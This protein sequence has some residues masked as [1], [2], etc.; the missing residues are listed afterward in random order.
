MI[1]ELDY[2]TY[3]MGFPKE[4]KGYYNRLSNLEIDSEDIAVYIAK[5]EHSLV[6]LHLD[7]FGRYPRR[8]VEIIT[9]DNIIIGDIINQNIKFLKDNKTIEFQEETNDKYI[10]EMRTF[11]KMY[12][13]KIVNTNSILEAN[14]VL[15]LAQ[16][17]EKE[18]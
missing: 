18:E 17:I 9:N 13:Q 11:L 12:E 2:I 5:Y 10:L 7:Y 3:I 15:T 14:E 4:L 8:Q 6:E 16:S 1:H